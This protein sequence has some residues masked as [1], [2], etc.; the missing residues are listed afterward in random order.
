MLAGSG[1]R[2]GLAKSAFATGLTMRSAGIMPP[3]KNL[4]VLTSRGFVQ[5]CGSR[6]FTPRL[7]R[8]PVRHSAGALAILVKGFSAIVRLLPHGCASNL[9][10]RK[11]SKRL[12]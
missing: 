11:N 3:E 12:P 7:E 5:V 6:I 8:L 10:L 2:E 9:S 1:Y 4:H